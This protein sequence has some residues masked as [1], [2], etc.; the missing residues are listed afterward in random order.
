MVGAAD[1]LVS[2][3][4]YLT[5]PD[6]HGIEIYCDRPREQWYNAQGTLIMDTLPLDAEG[7]LGELESNG[8]G[9]RG[10]S[11]KTVM[12]HVHLHVADLEAANNFY[13]DVMGFERPPLS[14]HIPTASFV[15]A[16]GYHHT[17]GLN[18]WA[19]VGA[20][21]PTSGH[22]RLLSF[23]LIFSNDDQLDRVRQYLAAAEVPQEKRTQGWLVRDPSQNPILLRAAK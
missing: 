20:P 15:S 5:D 18:I 10:L 13:L 4:L 2:E 16:G 8:H 9:W 6:G 22:A 7:I 19:G 11:A 23:E 12:G 1:H 21:A 14:M 3:A 17:L